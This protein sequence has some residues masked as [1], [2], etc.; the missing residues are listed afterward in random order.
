[1]DN[2]NCRKGAG[3]NFEVERQINKGTVITTVGEKMNGNTKWLLA[4]SNYYVSAS[5]M[6]FIRYI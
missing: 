6:E 4:K 5:Y 1:M 2:L 3:T